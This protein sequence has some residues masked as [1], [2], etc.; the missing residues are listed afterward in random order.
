[1]EF[2]RSFGRKR[3]SKAVTPLIAIAADAG[4]QQEAK[5]ND[6]LLSQQPPNRQSNGSDPGIT[7]PTF[8]QVCWESNGSSG[9][10]SPSEA[11][12]GGERSPFDNRREGLFAVN[13]KLLAKN[14]ESTNSNNNL[15]VTR[16][17]GLEIQPKVYYGPLGGHDSGQPSPLSLATPEKQDAATFSSGEVEDREPRSRQILAESLATWT[18]APKPSLGRRGAIY[19]SP[20][21]QRH[22]KSPSTSVDAANGRHSFDDDEDGLEREL[23]LGFSQAAALRGSITTTEEEEP[24]EAAA[25]P[26]AEQQ[27]RRDEAEEEEE[28]DRE[29][30]PSGIGNRANEEAVE[31]VRRL[32]RGEFQAMFSDFERAHMRSATQQIQ[33]QRTRSP[34]AGEESDPSEESGSLRHRSRSI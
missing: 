25:T 34:N 2:F 10:A 8:R 30:E 14:Q 21:R 27:K 33:R 4:Q 11:A 1:M 24:P 3:Q 9:P 29:P 19:V 17:P 12:R 23:D 5:S 31:A 32:G 6:S 15:R 20:N 26:L 7:G 28:N 13:N 16:S 18:H 22:E